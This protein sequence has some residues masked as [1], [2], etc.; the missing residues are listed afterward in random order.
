MKKHIEITWKD[1]HK[2]IKEYVP[3]NYC[4]AEDVFKV[5]GMFNNFPNFPDSEKTES[6][7]E[8]D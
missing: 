3:S 1:G 5:M 6:Y 4:N 7:I 2:T 8:L